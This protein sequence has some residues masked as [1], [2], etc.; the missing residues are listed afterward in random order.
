MAVFARLPVS[1]QMRDIGLALKSVL[2]IKKKNHFGKRETFG[3][4]SGMNMLSLLVSEPWIFL[5][6]ILAFGLSLS[7]HEFSHALAG[8]LLG[9]STAERMNRLT[10]NPLA[11]IDLWGFLSLL[12]IG[13]GWG[14]PVPYNPYNL[15]RGKWG[16]SLVSLAG[17][18]SNLCLGL[19]LSIVAG[20]VY[21]VLGS[22]NLLVIFLLYGAVLNFS[23][24]VFNLIPVVPLDGSAPL[25]A[26][27][28]QFGWRKAA[29]GLMQYGPNILFGLVLLNIAFNIPIF[30]WISGLAFF[31]TDTIISLV[32]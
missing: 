24:M 19:I 8:K 9:D 5:A 22:T 25:L 1:M 23:L 21:P 26:I 30:S 28:E 11:H 31:L 12:L 2:S 4:Y 14:K 3:H 20:L 6:I 13:F 7:V 15:K 16:P 27:F 32:A 18:F 29:V 17:P 10:L